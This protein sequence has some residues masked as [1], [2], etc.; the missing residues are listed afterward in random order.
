VLQCRA[1]REERFGFCHKVIKT[2]P[3]VALILITFRTKNVGQNA[4]HFQGRTGHLKV[5]HHTNV[6][7]LVTLVIHNT[8]RL[9]PS[10]EL[11]PDLYDSNLFG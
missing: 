9:I 11:N 5:G 10:F 1:G 7:R 3:I 2:L 4:G 8:K 6:G